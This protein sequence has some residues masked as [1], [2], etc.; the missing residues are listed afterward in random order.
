MS[1]TVPNQI[2]KHY[3][4]E[5]KG[6][7]TVILLTQYQNFNSVKETGVLPLILNCNLQNRPN[8][9]GGGLN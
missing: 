9:A 2:F 4:D 3:R 5:G 1:K 8:L 6:H 7:F